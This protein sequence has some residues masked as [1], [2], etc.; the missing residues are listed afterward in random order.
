MVY[1]TQCMVYVT[2]CM[3]YVTQCMVYVTQ[4]MVYVTQ[5]MIY[6]TQCKVYVTQCMIYVTQCM[7]YVTQCIYTSLSVWCPWYSQLVVGY[8][9]SIAWHS[10]L[11]ITSPPEG[12]ARYCFHQVC[13]SVCLCVWFVCLCVCPANIFCILFSQL[14]EDISFWNLYRILTCI[15]LY[16]IHWTKRDGTLLFE[17]TVISQKLSHRIFFS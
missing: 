10:S 7:I 9:A 3:V 8:C 16:S 17:G 14:L 12:V 11:L 13:L 2:Q 4:C 15:G 1:V 6:V 5:C